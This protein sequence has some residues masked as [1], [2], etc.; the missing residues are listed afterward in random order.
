MKAHNPIV[1]LHES[2]YGPEL[3]SRNARIVV[4]MESKADVK[5]TSSQVRCWTRCGSRA[6]HFAVT[7]NAPCFDV[8]RCQRRATGNS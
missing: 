4:A 8:V 6:R 1:A 5:R 3:T 7:H 2:A